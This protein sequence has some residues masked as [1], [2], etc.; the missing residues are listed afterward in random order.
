MNL[1]NRRVD[2]LGMA[3]LENKLEA[4]RSLSYPTT[5]SNLEYYLDLAS[6]LRNYIYYFA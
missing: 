3:T 2:S 1:L 6:Y 5:L 4:I